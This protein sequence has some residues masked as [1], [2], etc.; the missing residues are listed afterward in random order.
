MSFQE[1]GAGRS[2]L[3]IDGDY[4]I[5]DIRG[6]NV[7]SWSTTDDDGQRRAEVVLIREATDR[8]QF[9]VLL[10]R[11]IALGDQARQVQ[12]PVVRVLDAMLHTGMLQIRRSDLLN[13]VAS[14]TE[15]VSRADLAPHRIATLTQ[16]AQYDEGP[17]GIEAF[18]AYRFTGNDYNL[19]FDVSPV[20]TRSSADLQTIVR[21]TEDEV[22]VEC[23]VQMQV[24]QRDVHV[25]RLHVP[26]DLKIES[27]DTPCARH[28]S[29]ASVDDQAQSQRLTIHLA[30]GLAGEFS[31]VFH[32]T[33]QRT[34]AQ[35]DV[36]LPQIEVIDVDAQ[37]GAIAIQIDP[38]YSATATDLQ[39]CGTVLRGTVNRW[40]QPAQQAVTTLAIG[41]RNTGYSGTIRV[42]PEQAEVKGQAFTNVRVTQR[43]IQELIVIALDVSRAGID[44]FSFLLPERMADAV[45]EQ[46]SLRRK[47]ISNVE[48]R[49]G[50]IRV[51]IEL[52]DNVL[53][54]VRTLVRD[55]RLPDETVQSVPI[56]II[57]TGQTQGR[58]V[59][60]ENEGRDEVVIDEPKGLESLGRLHT[61]RRVLADIFDNT[62]GDA[63][64]VNAAA[65]DPSLTFRLRPRSEVQ[66]AGARIGKAETILMVDASGTYR[67]AVEFRVNNDIE[68]FLEI[69]LPRDAQLWTVSVADEPVKPTLVPDAIGREQVRIPLVKTAEGDTDYAVVLK[70]GGFIDLTSVQ[71][72]VRFPL[73]HTRN[74]NV[75]MSQVRLLLPESHR[76]FRFD[77]TMQRVDHEGEYRAVDLK[78]LTDQFRLLS[79]ALSSE[80]AYSKAR[81]ESNL[82]KL[83]QQVLEHQQAYADLYR[84]SEA[85]KEE[86]KFNALSQQQ[87]AEQVIENKRSANADRKTSQMAR[88]EFYFG[89][90]SLSHSRQVVE[91]LGQSGNFQ[92]VVPEQQRGSEPAEKQS[93]FDQSWFAKNGLA[94]GEV[95]DQSENLKK[96]NI[97]DKPSSKP[98]SKRI[99]RMDEKEARSSD[100]FSKPLVFSEGRDLA[101]SQKPR[102]MQKEIHD[103]VRQYRQRLQEQEIESEMGMGS[104]MGMAGGMGGGMGMGS[105]MA[106]PR[107]ASES[108]E[109]A[110]ARGSVALEE[111]SGFP[112]DPFGSGQGGAGGFGLPSMAVPGEPATDPFSVEA[113]ANSND[114]ALNEVLSAT[115]PIAG[116]DYLSSLET[117]F[118]FDKGG[119]EFYFVAP[120]GEIE[121]EATAVR[122]TTFTRIKRLTAMTILML[123]V[124]A[125]RR[126]SRRR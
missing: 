20:R 2:R 44:Q 106:D 82:R 114:F 28:W 38:A 43:T 74:I 17:L 122:Q 85:V 104:G 1:V 55:N 6:G 59:T 87:A 57:E 67:A 102:E 115:I 95:T 96:R 7:R 62:L 46:P 23:K 24:R 94:D 4:M 80:N 27:V 29:T 63:F 79:S 21:I 58:F 117:E 22:D 99:A 89:Q 71:S 19:L 91:D 65:D 107:P 77:G 12:A 69:D 81:A 54:D 34:D 120:R 25:L 66:T 52:Q 105:G 109:S 84:E 76:W 3:E 11:P 26:T 13:V 32:G 53:G 112:N 64:V 86:A 47:T 97:A 108:E 16:G 118:P 78:H 35:Q 72:K 31:F 8:E 40:L 90:G 33:S 37:Q 56:P 98:E 100:R 48:D 70:Y 5:Q 68:Q 93:D 10:G 45:I 103:D 42:T 88:L 92:A 83:D 123:G 126:V 60:L 116:K 9:S 73:V 49:P 39:Q 14:E 101:I 110:P 121:I 41:Y 113:D 75:E 50:W 36:P 30:E 51:T 61:Q 111:Q 125:V 15:G 18:Q 119:T 124:L